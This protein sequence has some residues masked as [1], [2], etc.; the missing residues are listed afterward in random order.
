MSIKRTLSIILAAAA[1]CACGSKK[2]EPVPESEL[3]ELM[4]TVPSDALAV[5]DFS[6]C[7]KGMD[8]QLDSTTAINRLDLKEF[9]S[10]RITIS[11]VFMGKLVP[12]L[13]I[14]AGRA[15]ADTS[16]AVRSLIR[17]AD[18]LGISSMFLPQ[19]VPGGR[20]S[21]VLLTTSQA[22]IPSVDRHL[23]SHSSIVEAPGFS[24]AYRISG[25]KPDFIYLRNSGVDKTLPRTFLSRYISPRLTARFLQGAADWM[26][27][28][29]G[30]GADKLEMSTVDNGSYSQYVNLL[31]DLEPAESRLAS[32]LPQ[33]TEFVIDL[34]IGDG[35]RGHYEDYLDAC[36]M[37]ESYN[38]GIAE[39]RKN[40]GI[41]PV[42]W[43]KSNG[44]K[45]V[46]I[47]HWNNRKVVLYRPA[48]GSRSEEIVKN[49]YAGFPALLYGGVFELDNDLYCGNCGK[50]V[51]TGSEP[52]V[53]A[54]LQ[55]S[56]YLQASDWPQKN[57]KFAVLGPGMM[58]SWSKDKLMLNLKK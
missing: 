40:A 23:E 33:D 15:S 2:G 28:N 57:C 34:P 17:Q 37:L 54:F 22:A 30:D 46:A 48:K 4:Q 14:E 35:F 52:D 45:E 18:T 24:D 1:I 27:I 19:G 20:H 55:T 11:Y 58:F 8:M 53:T 21:I 6:R 43:E 39:L 49:P 32:V 41:S 31:A 10:S 47:V 42:D 13:A 36:R 3:P 25:G 29:A 26:V 12:V 51:V 7:D 38:A 56:N 44:I 9:R 50:W 16:E 5:L